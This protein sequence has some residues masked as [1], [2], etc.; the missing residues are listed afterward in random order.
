MSENQDTDVKPKKKPLKSLKDFPYDEIFWSWYGREKEG[1]ENIFKKT[2]A[3]I[4]LKGDKAFLEH[5]VDILGRAA[6]IIRAPH[7]DDNE[8]KGYLS[9]EYR[10][11]FQ[12]T[13]T[14]QRP[15]IEVFDNYLYHWAMKVW[16]RALD[17]IHETCRRY[18]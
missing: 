2:I 6:N 10:E 18:R 7:R 17:I 16:P 9:S 13:P 3:D 15:T 11:Y 14:D 8:F 5:L 4:G 12:N 1:N